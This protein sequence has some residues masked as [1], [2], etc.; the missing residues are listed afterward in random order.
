[1]SLKINTN[2]LESNLDDMPERLAVAVMMIADTK[3]K[4]IEAYAKTNRKWRD[5]TNQA[6]ANLR[7]VASRP[8][9]YLVRITLSHGVDYGIWLEL[10]NEKRYAIIQ[11]TLDVYGPKVMSS[12]D[13]LMNRLGVSR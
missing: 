13:G 8:Q 6:K 12:L 9:R 3:S 4:E 7:C 10:A 5:R 11:P 1:M 2:E